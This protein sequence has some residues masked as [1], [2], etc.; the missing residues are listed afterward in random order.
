MKET[1]GKG[2]SGKEVSPLLDH[3]VDEDQKEIRE[4]RK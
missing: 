2:G 4:K 1:C 3:S